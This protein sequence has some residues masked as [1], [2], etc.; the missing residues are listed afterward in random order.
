MNPIRDV[1]SFSNACCADGELVV[2]FQ[3]ICSLKL[4]CNSP[5]FSL[6]QRDSNGQRLEKTGKKVGSII[7]V[8][9]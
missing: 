5:G 1:M 8:T 9:E 3:Q 6:Y 4:G 7:E 2:F